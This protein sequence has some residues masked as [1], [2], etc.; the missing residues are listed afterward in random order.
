MAKKKTKKDKNGAKKDKKREEEGS[1]TK[2]KKKAGTAATKKAAKKAAEELKNKIVEKFQQNQFSVR[3]IQ[4]QVFNITDFNQL[5]TLKNSLPF[6]VR[7]VKQVYQRSF[8]GGTALFDIEITQ[9][10]ET[11]ASELAAKT[12]EGLNFEIVGVTQNKVTAKIKST[13]PE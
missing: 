7:G 12:I 8:G 13:T 4:L 11:V 9:K 5:N 2:A 6:Y 10:A 3:Q 1:L